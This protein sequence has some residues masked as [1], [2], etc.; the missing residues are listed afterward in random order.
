M[1][2]LQIP[3]GT[4][5]ET[6]PVMQPAEPVDAALPVEEQPFDAS[7]QQSNPVEV[8]G[9]ADVVRRGAQAIAK[10]IEDA[11]PIG[12]KDL[13]D[14]VEKH[15]DFW[16]IRQPTDD[17]I[18]VFNSGVDR[19][20]TG[21]PSPSKAQRAAGIPIAQVNYERMKNPQD[22]RELL[23]GL[24]TFYTDYVKQMKRGNVSVKDTIANAD[25]KGIG[26][27]I[28]VLSNRQVGRPLSDEEVIG[29]AM[30][31][32]TRIQELDRLN[33]LVIDGSA[34]DADRRHFATEFAL[35]SQLGAQLLGGTAENS[36][37]L[38]ASRVGIQVNAGWVDA[39]Q[40][41][42]SEAGDKGIDWLAHQYAVLPTQEAKAKFT[43]GIL[44]KAVDVWQEVWINSLLSSITT[45]A[46]NVGANFA[47]LGLQIPERL[48]AGVIGSAR[49][50]ITGS[51]EGVRMREAAALTHGIGQ[52]FLDGLLL[53]A[54]A[55]R[56]EA[57]QSGGLKSKLESREMKAITAEKFGLDP[58]SNA[59]RAV[60]YLGVAVRLPG[61]FLIAEDEFFKGVSGRMQLHALAYRE[62]MENIDRGMPLQQ[63]KQNYEMA[64]RNPSQ[65]MLDQIGD[66]QSVVTFQKDLEGVI[67]AVGQGMTHPLAKMFVPFFKTPT[68]VVRAVAERSPLVV[69]MPS[70]YKAVAAGGAEADA[71]LARVA[72]G[73]SV[74]ATWAAFAG[75][76]M[77]DDVII[78]GSGPGKAGARD[79]MRRQNFDPYTISFRQEDGTYKSVSYSRFDPISG[80]LA[81]GA[82]FAEYAK[83]EDDPSVLE[84]MTLGM[85]LAASEYLKQ[86]PMVQGA[87]NI[88][89]LMGGDFE[90]PQERLAGAVDLLTKQFASTILGPLSGGSMMASIERY[91]SPD[92]SD[93]KGNPDLPPG[94][95]GFY[96]ALQQAKSRNPFFSILLGLD[97]VPPKLNLWGEKIT[98]DDMGAATMFSP[99]KIKNAQF[100]VVDDEITKLNYALGSSLKMPPRKIDG[101]GLTATQY[102]DLLT[103]MNVETIGGKTMLESMTSEVTSGDYQ[104]MGVD[105]KI[106]SL[107]DIMADYLDIAQDRV[108]RNNPALEANVKINK[109]PYEERKVIKQDDGVMDRINRTLD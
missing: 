29:G 10:K 26:F 1:D 47:Y 67:G 83:Y 35:T 61:R 52:G 42:V 3:L 40:K 41:M 30:A 13:V 100:N 104:R 70:F 92:L 12:A 89:A 90:S 103:F 106:K 75:G 38:A 44:G 85:V 62:M 32:G 21:V 17:E 48:L 80:L 7:I 81:M 5:N 86:L 101:V 58:V 31:L 74:M 77:G 33:K 63:A 8:A 46:V 60:E 69:A 79:A 20:S 108:V 22:E 49:R 27:F 107:R 19:Q 91:N 99:I 73:T 34:T 54:K 96:E 65:T 28:D 93:T 102:N 36:R 18:K 14:H 45:H 16:V 55:F 98:A 51:T 66:F 6:L 9:L 39:M 94:I 84:Q 50:S 43:K 2:D 11:K 57:P 78:T 87:A 59:G 72:L 95:K 4:P 56:D 25:K 109:M 82:D 88:T 23:D 71:A 24:L 15:G 68:N 97:N 53:A 76:G 37:A 105:D 64:L